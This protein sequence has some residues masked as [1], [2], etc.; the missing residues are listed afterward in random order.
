L[1]L[2]VIPPQ[3]S[4]SFSRIIPQAV[5]ARYGL[6]IGAFFAIPVRLLIFILSPLAYPIGKLLDYLLG[7]HSGTVYRRAELKELLA[8]HGEDY[9]GPLG[10]DEVGILKAVLSMK[11][12]EVIHVM[13]DLEYV[14][15]LDLNGKLDKDTIQKACIKS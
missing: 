3:I 4:F 2:I 9:H 12:K 14:V 8:L 5:C 6:A 10:N 13:T 1:K 11:E 7:S 15:M